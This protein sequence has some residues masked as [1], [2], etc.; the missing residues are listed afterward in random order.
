MGSEHQDARCTSDRGPVR[1][2][3]APYDILRIDEAL[4]EANLNVA[5][6]AGRMWTADHLYPLLPWVRYCLDIPT[7]SVMTL[8]SL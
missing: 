6:A 8:L 7:R 2:Q 5:L 1:L 3:P 4:P